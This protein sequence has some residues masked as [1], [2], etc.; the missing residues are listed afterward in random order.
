MFVYKFQISKFDF[1]AKS[2][3]PPRPCEIQSVYTCIKF[4]NLIENIS[5]INLK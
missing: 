5:E 2:S 4:F 1:F 3:R